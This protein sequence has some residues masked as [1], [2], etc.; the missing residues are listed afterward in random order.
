MI[1]LVNIS[2]QMTHDVY[3]LSLYHHLY[4]LATSRVLLAVFVNICP[5]AHTYFNLEDCK[6]I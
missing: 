4:P 6:R 3:M 1:E 2:E 5:T